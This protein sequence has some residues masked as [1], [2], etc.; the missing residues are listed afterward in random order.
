MKFVN[1]LKLGL[2][3]LFDLFYTPIGWVVWIFTNIDITYNF[4]KY[5]DDLTKKM[6]ENGREVF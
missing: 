5:K 4:K 6:F 3:Y 2:I 1:R